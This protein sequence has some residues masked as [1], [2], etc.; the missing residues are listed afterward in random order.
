MVAHRHSGAGEDDSHRG[1]PVSA[2]CD[3]PTPT[4]PHHGFVSCEATALVSVLYVAKAVCLS[5][6]NTQLGHV[7]QAVDMPAPLEHL[8]CKRLRGSALEMESYLGPVPVACL[9]SDPGT[10]QAQDSVGASI[11]SPNNQVVPIGFTE[12]GN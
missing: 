8:F 3:T 11:V 9:S 5:S 7:G 1:S 10:C 12:R 4:P 6:G 2:T